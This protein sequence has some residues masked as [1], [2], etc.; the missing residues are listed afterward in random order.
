MLAPVRPEIR[1]DRIA[2]RQGQLAVS[3][4]AART[5]RT[6][7]GWRRRCSR[8]PAGSPTTA[9]AS[10]PSR[11]T[12]SRRLPPSTAAASSTPCAPPSRS[13]ATS[14]TSFPARSR[15]SW[16]A[17]SGRSRPFYKAGPVIRLGRIPADRFAAFIEA[18]YARQRHQVR[19]R[20]RPGDRRAGRQPALRRAAP[21]ARAVGR[22]PRQRTQGAGPRRPARHADAAA[23]RTG[24]RSSRRPGS[25]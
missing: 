23:G 7:R 6:C 8:C 22:R 19:A 12:S 11:S 18:R 15:R 4:P 25:G 14:A 20:P 5:E 10:W 24:D 1:I 3:F 21:R 13:S 9:A 17:C 16:S 2:G